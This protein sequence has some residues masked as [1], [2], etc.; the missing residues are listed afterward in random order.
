M[1]MIDD[2]MR[3]QS[4]NYVACSLS[5]QIK[6]NQIENSNF[7]FRTTLL[8]PRRIFSIAAVLCSSWYLLMSQ[9]GRLVSYI[10]QQG[11]K[12]IILK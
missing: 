11:W 8:A 7:H 3:I 10:Y 4:S 2:D 6:S 12:V 5:N 1:A 9:R